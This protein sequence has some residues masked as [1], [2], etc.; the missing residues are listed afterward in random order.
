MSLAIAVPVLRS[1]APATIAAFAVFNLALGAAFL[2]HYVFHAA[3]QRRWAAEGLIDG[4]WAEAFPPGGLV[5]FLVWAI[6]EHTGRMMAYP[7]G[8]ARHASSLTLLCVV[9]GVAALWRR[10][11]RDVLAVCLA[12][13][14]L[15]FLAAVV[16]K[17]PYGGSARTM[18]FIAP[19]ICLLAGV[20]GATALAAFRKPARRSLAVGCAAAA[21]VV[22]GAG[23]AVR[24]AA[25]P[26]HTAY[27]RDSAA[28]A[29]WFWA[30][31]SRGAEIACVSTDLGH[32]LG[33]GRWRLHAAN[34][35]CNQRLFSPSHRA[36][37]RL[38]DWSRIAEDHPL[39]CVVFSRAEHPPAQ[40]ALA[41]WL[42][43]M[44][45]DF[46]LVD[47]ARHTVNS[48]VEGYAEVYEVYEFA[49]RTSETPAEF[50]R[51]RNQRTAA[52][53]R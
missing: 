39:R 10:G 43:E 20:G 41:A 24:D 3:P 35:R 17:Y 38:P 22:I 11:R 9:G 32:E 29:R 42:D 8:G 5:D 44:R 31:C 26:H 33:G 23:A 4:M 50:A 27:D 1:R 37:P 47:S 45:A 15:A 7:V 19:A 14:A 52:P 53:A 13:A 2:I 18:Q 48:G 34:Y 25:R 6:R 16:H 28:F 30:E 46:W 36:G 49:P 40:P 21:L 12:P 51:R